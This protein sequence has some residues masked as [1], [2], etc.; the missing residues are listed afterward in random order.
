MVLGVGAGAG[1]AGADV[2]P[3]VI[4]STNK[5]A[6]KTIIVPF[7]IPFNACSG[8]MFLLSVSLYS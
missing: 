7:I 6:M 4:R 8:F 3:A 1:P 2:H 5:R